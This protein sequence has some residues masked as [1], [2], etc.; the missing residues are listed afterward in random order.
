MA[1]CLHIIPIKKATVL[2]V[3]SEISCTDLFYC[4]CLNTKILFER[5]ETNIAWNAHFA[6][7]MKHFATFLTALEV[8][9]LGS[10]VAAC[11][12]GQQ[13]DAA[14]MVW[15]LGFQKEVGVKSKW[16]LVMGGKDVD[17]GDDDDDEEDEEEEDDENNDDIQK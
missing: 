5:Y 4:S 17:D 8:V 9:T 15:N 13:L 11:G 16:C 12:R 14:L 1:Q 7:H 6:I 2:V 10:V 3:Y